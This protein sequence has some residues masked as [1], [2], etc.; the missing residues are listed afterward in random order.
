MKQSLNQELARTGETLAVDYLVTNG[1][2]V[3]CR[4]FRVK[5]GEID[6]IVEK[7]QHLIFVEVKTR[8]YHSI[9]TA[10]DNVSYTKQKHISRVAQ[11][12]C[13]QNPQYDKFNTR[14]DVIV[15]LFNARNE[16]FSIHHFPDAFLPIAD[17]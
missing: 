15:L 6:I 12:Y 16:E 14:F 8:S 13:K 7:N 11:V 5:Q 3:L 17:Q 10:L 4:N 9:Q 2:N 1:Y